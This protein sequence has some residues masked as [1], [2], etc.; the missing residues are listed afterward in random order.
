MLRELGYKKYL[1]G[2]KVNSFPLSLVIIGNFAFGKDAY[3]SLERIM[4]IN[5]S[6]GSMSLYYE[7][8]SAAV[9]ITFDREQWVDEEFAKNLGQTL[10]ARI[11]LYMRM[12]HLFIWDK[13]NRIRKV[14]KSDP[15]KI[16]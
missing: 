7:E 6:L 10:R 16:S 3:L 4:E 1:R 9:F 11:R 14:E 15:S 13:S 2:A 12:W 5:K 8:T